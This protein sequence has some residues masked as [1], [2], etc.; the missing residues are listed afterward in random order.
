MRLSD[1]LRKRIQEKER[2]KQANRLQE[3]PPIASPPVE[4]ALE[5]SW[6]VAP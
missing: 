5:E 4:Q 3:K 6:K 1:R 2:P